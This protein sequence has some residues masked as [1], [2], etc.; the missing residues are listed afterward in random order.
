MFG[1][2][3]QGTHRYGLIKGNCGSEAFDWLIR[4]MPG[5]TPG[6]DG[7]WLLVRRREGERCRWKNW[8][9]VDMP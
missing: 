7:G 4:G 9:R 2:D 6:G 3:D 1:R 5:I 8:A